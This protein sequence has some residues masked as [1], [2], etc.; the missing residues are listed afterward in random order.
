MN[1]TY[2]SSQKPKQISTQEYM[3]T[4]RCYDPGV[5]LGFGKTP[6]TKLP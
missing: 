2:L 4:K 6:I 5:I 1:L 3:K